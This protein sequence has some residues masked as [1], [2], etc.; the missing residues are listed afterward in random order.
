MGCLVI[1]NWQPS[2]DAVGIDSQGENYPRSVNQFPQNNGL[3]EA[4]H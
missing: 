1:S 3:N 2:I 4:V